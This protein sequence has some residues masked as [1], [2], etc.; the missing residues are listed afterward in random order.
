V[1]SVVLDNAHVDLGDD[2]LLE[3]NA[4]NRETYENLPPL[5]SIPIPPPPGL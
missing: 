5:A 3:N 4:E 2:N 1:F